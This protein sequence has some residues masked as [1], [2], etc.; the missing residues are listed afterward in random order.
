M[1]SF[2]V[3]SFDQNICFLRLR[4]GLR[5][6]ALEKPPFSETRTY[7]CLTPGVCHCPQTLQLCFIAMESSAAHGWLPIA[8]VPTPSTAVSLLLE[9]IESWS[10][11]H[12]QNFYSL[13][14]ELELSI[15]ILKT[16][17]EASTGQPLA[18]GHPAGR[19]ATSLCVSSGSGEFCAPCH[20]HGWHMQT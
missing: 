12:H 16:L 7:C 11:L 17:E 8:C 6:A 20:L 13:I 4:P 3:Y 10:F 14:W 9:I 19:Q 18:D 1:S 2:I 15:S 5:R